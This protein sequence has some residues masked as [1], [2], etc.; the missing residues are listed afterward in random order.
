MEKKE[1]LKECIVETIKAYENKNE[2]GGLSILQLQRYNSILQKIPYNTIYHL[3]VLL[4]HDH[5]IIAIKYKNQQYFKL[6]KNY[7]LMGIL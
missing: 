2:I 3:C 4:K 7:N 6:N 1:F 5:K